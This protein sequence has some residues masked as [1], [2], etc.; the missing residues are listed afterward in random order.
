MSAL[1]RLPELAKYE[2]LEEIGHGG[3]ATVYRARDRRLGREVAVKLIHRHLRDSSEVAER[4]AREA[5]TVAKLRHPSI[6]EVFDIS[7]PDE[8][9]RYLVVELVRGLTLRERLRSGPLPPE[10]AAAVALEVGAGLE[11]AHSQGV[12]HRDVKPENVLIELPRAGEG[13]EVRER[14]PLRLKLTDF[15]IAKLLDAQGVTS[16]G[17]VLGSPAHMAPEQIEG[18]AVDART[19][20]FAL[21]VLLYEAMVGRLPFHGE[22][23]AQVLRRVLDGEFTPAERQDARVGAGYSRVISRA[24]ARQR[25]DRFESVQALLDALRQELATLGF[26]KLQPLLEAVMRPDPQFEDELVSRLVE[27]GTQARQDGQI[28]VAAEYFGRALAYRPGDRQ[29][30]RRV[31]GLAR[32]RE[33]RRL[34]RGA[35]VVGGVAALGALFY[36]QSGTGRE[37]RDLTP[38]LTREV[39][40]ASAPS[41]SGGAAPSPASSG[42]PAAPPAGVA[43]A[44]G[45]PVHV[46]APG[47][48]PPEPATGKAEPAASQ[49]RPT[50]RAGNRRG[51]AGEAEALTSRDVVVRITGATGGTLRI[52]GEPVQWF[53]D[54]HHSL[55]L[56]PHRFEFVAPDSNCCVSSERT[57]NIVAGEGPQQVNGEIPFLDAIVRVSAEEGVSGL[58]TC[59]SLFSGDQ[60]F[61][62]DVHIKMS[63]VSVGPVTCT[64]RGDDS[65]A[66]PQKSEVTLRAGQ[67]QVIPWP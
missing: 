7:D 46:T 65:S 40:R 15:G 8:P 25:E 3:M 17:Q 59:P 2:L 61:P 50:L 28:A 44:G 33:L 35:A 24:L 20:V 62:G 27:R 22:H 56:G 45:A 5:T 12:I 6:V 57:V 58:L 63:R 23:P 38:P 54:V 53:G 16:T 14:T 48:Q 36:H 51:A 52:D 31:S 9:E 1:L 30:L 37:R 47:S 21:G 43:G 67:T 32:D 55:P 4:F 39:P 34:L 11:H 66:P 42:L 18:G 10:V 19:D 60:R 41:V 29:L 26:T 64:L 49:V 13:G